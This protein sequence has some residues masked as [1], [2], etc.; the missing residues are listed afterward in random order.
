M[1][2]QAVLT[3]S[4]SKRDSMCHRYFRCI[5]ES[6]GK[7]I[8]ESTSFFTCSIIWNPT[9]L[10]IA[11]ASHGLDRPSALPMY[12][13][14]ILA[15]CLPPGCIVMMSPPNNNYHSDFTAQY[16]VTVCITVVDNI[17]STPER[18]LISQS[19]D[20]ESTWRDCQSI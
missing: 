8:I 2:L 20:L 9:L 13:Q 7:K 14:R 11:P 12:L 1:Q 5:P 3:W 16:I 4:L 17:P 19:I 18:H 10:N 6:S 15:L